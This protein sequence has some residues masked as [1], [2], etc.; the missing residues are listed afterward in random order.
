MGP[1]AVDLPDPL[2]N[3]EPPPLALQGADD[4]LSQLVGDQIDR[5]M[6]DDRPT[7]VL[8]LRAPV[9]DAQNARALE[10]TPPAIKPTPANSA[11]DAQIIEEP[12][13]TQADEIF[14][15]EEVYENAI[16][17]PAA[18]PPSAEPPPSAAPPPPAD[19]PADAPDDAESDLAQE[20]AEDERLGDRIDATSIEQ[21]TENI[22][23]QLDELLAEVDLTPVPFMREP[24]KTPV[25]PV[26]EIPMYLAPLIWANA[27]VALLPAWARKSLGVVSV[28]LFVL[29]LGA[30]GYVMFLR[31][32]AAL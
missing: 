2:N 7:P 12:E 20:L 30:L 1:S 27:P 16:E 25:A 10:P 26:P 5:L 31:H 23:S 18:P 15:S 19:Q 6:R 21:A 17:Q 28:L 8:D 14:E 32:S 3:P 9:G 22:R 24:A 4:L 11:P 29:A 13:P